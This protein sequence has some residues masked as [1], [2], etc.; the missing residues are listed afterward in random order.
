MIEF[1]LALFAFVCGGVVGW[2]AHAYA[3]PDVIDTKGP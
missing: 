2:F 3:S 1:A